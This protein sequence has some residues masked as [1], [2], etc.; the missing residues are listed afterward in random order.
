MEFSWQLGDYLAL[1]V[2]NQLTAAG[3]CMC[4]DHFLIITFDT[5]KT[6]SKGELS[7]ARYFLFVSFADLSAHGQLQA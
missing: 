5:T 2:L 6:L 1:L 7:G 3:S 4:L